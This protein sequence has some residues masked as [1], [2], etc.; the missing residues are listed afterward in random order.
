V[1]PPAGAV[2]SV[3]VPSLMRLRSGIDHVSSGLA[4]GTMGGGAVC[5]IALP[6]SAHNTKQTAIKH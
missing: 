3:T 2:I 1:A 6:A 5:D 4:L